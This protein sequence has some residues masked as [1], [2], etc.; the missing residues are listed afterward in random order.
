[1]I[2]ADIV[3]VQTTEG[4]LDTQ[5]TDPAAEDAASV[6]RCYA[7]GVV[8]ELLQTAAYAHA[9]CAIAQPA[10][11]ARIQQRVEHIMRRQH[12]LDQ[13]DPPKLWVLVEEAVLRRPFGGTEVWRDQLEH[14]ARAAERKHVTIQ[15]VPDYVGGPAISGVPFTLLRFD[16]P[17]IDDVVCLRHATD[18]QFLCEREDLETYC[19]VWDRLSVHAMPP[20]YTGD[21]IHALIAG[22]LDPP[23]RHQPGG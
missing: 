11:T 22:R 1:V 14:L 7:A 13:H 20:E 10:P 4:V 18:T 19:K 16:S 6:V 2:S 12:L 21:L 17:G 5:Y 9:V 3:S 15:I 23:P 8:P